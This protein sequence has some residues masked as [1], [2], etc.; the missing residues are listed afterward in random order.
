MTLETD[1]KLS[2]L[3]PISFRIDSNDF[4]GSEIRF[5]RLLKLIRMSLEAQRLDLNDFGS[6]LVSSKSLLV[7][8]S[9]ESPVETSVKSFSLV[10]FWSEILQA[11]PN[12]PKL[13]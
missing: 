7:E 8:S 13:E 1:S 3:I 12:R 4:L 9:V 10:I 5:E 11:P 6:N 2:D